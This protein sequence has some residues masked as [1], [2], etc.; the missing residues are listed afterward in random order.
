MEAPK[1]KGREISIW[2]A[3]GITS[4]VLI[5]VLVL[6]TLFAAGGVLLDRYFQTTAV[7]TI[8]GFI[9]LVVIGYPVIKKKATRI[10]KRMEETSKE[11]EPNTH[12]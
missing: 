3:L 8:I 9:L 5:T 1:S 12:A 11:N 10:A 4:D 6:T 7:F 2:E